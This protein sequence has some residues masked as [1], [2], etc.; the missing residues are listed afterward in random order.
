MHRF[1]PPGSVSS[2]PA[3][4]DAPVSADASD[5]VTSA[6]GSIAV[7]EVRDGTAAG[8]GEPDA[9]GPAPSAAPDGDG[10]PVGPL[11]AVHPVKVPASR[12]LAAKIQIGLICNSLRGCSAGSART[13]GSPARSPG[14]PSR[15]DPRTGTGRPR[16]RR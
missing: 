13:A 10:P 12:A 4:Y 8:L 1:E 7:D 16:R 9:A 6:Q 11:D 14:V 3:P 15:S 5:W 2:L